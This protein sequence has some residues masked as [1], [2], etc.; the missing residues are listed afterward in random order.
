MIYKI[1]IFNRIKNFPTKNG[2]K[3]TLFVDL[4]KI[5]TGHLYVDEELLSGLGYKKIGCGLV[6]L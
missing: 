1:Y 3:G 6:A 5:W 2:A 4:D